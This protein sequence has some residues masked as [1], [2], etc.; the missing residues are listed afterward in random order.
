MP[1]ANNAGALYLQGWARAS[2]SPEVTACE[3]MGLR[4]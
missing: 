1:H 4:P 2:T 3:A